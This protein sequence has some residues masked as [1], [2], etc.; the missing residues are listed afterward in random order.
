MTIDCKQKIPTFQM[1]W[2]VHVL[3]C[4]IEFPQEKAKLI[5]HLLQ[6]GLRTLAIVSRKIDR[7]LFQDLDYKLTKAQQSITDREE[8][9][10]EIFEEIEQE[11][12]L[13]GATAVEDK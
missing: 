6:L 12:H 8:K 9:L 3:I 4:F 11:F 13:L 10:A 7:N 5:F 1:N 2:I